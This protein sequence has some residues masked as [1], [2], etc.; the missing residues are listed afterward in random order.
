VLLIRKFQ[1][2]GCE[3]S[4]WAVGDV[5]GAT[6]GAEVART[7]KPKRACRQ[8]LA[9]DIYQH[10]GYRVSLRGRAVS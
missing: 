6:S 2:D 8:L 3:Y 9:G 5:A 4:E 7:D 10:L 1:D